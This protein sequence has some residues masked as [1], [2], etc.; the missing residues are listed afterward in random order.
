MAE[1]VPFEQENILFSSI[2]YNKSLKLKKIWNF[3]ICKIL[4]IL[5]HSLINL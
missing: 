5:F 3:F 2:K 1:Y 4:F